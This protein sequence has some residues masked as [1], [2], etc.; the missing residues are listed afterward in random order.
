MNGLLIELSVE[1]IECMTGHKQAG[2]DLTREF[3]RLFA[4]SVQSHTA[5]S[6]VMTPTPSEN[7]TVEDLVRGSD[8]VECS[9]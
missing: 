1:S 9:G 8:H 6:A 5:Y 2:L 4:S 7:E 3:T